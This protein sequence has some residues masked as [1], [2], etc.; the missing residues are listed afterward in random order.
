MILG[1][2][3]ALATPTA[4][5]P[6]G[7][8]VTARLGTPPCGQLSAPFCREAEGSPKVT[9][10]VIQPPGPRTG[11]C[12]GP[13]PCCV[14][15]WPL[16]AAGRGAGGPRSGGARSGPGP[17]H[18]GRRVGGSPEGSRNVACVLLL[19]DEELAG[20]QAGGRGRQAGALLAVRAERDSA[21]H[22]HPPPRVALGVRAPGRRKS[23][24][25]LSSLPDVRGPC[26][27]PACIGGLGRVPE[28]G[29][30]DLLGP[31]RSALAPTVLKASED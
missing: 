27:S 31:G 8:G 26:S 22:V 19:E 16:G 7:G 10:C 1:P 6:T 4:G 20:R 29:G 11:A 15:A 25:R 21:S 13:A 5:P 28:T 9:R 30:L 18:Q 23:R 3:W 24:P 17:E 12:D 14:Q 2:A